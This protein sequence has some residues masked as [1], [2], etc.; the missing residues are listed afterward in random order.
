MRT[1]QEIQ[2]DIGW[3]ESKDVR[4]L[5]RQVMD[6]CETIKSLESRVTELEDLVTPMA[7]EKE[8]MSSV[9]LYKDAGR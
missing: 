4:V 1:P 2:D 6:L 3:T 5:A 8:I 9:E 7:Q